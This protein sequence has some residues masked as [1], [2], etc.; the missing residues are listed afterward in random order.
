MPKFL[1]VL[2]LLM[3]TINLSAQKTAKEDIIYLKNKWVIR[4]QIT[5]S[6]DNAVTIVTRDGNVF[7]FQPSEIQSLGKENKKRYKGFG[8][9]TEIGALAATKNRPDNV[10]TAAF[11]FQTVNGYRF[12]SCLFLGVG[13]ALDLYAT[14]TIL[15][16]FASIRYNLTGKGNFQP[17]LFSDCGY[18]FD[19]TSST[20]NINYES[21]AMFAIGAG[22]KIPLANRAG[23]QVSAG[24]RLQRGAIIESGVKNEYSNNR[25]ALRAGFYL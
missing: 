15:P 25:I 4:G 21:G 8:H 22:L 3:S 6:S 18:G 17:F 11:T 10:T 7:V 2:T 20:T 14:Q 9:Y 16:G 19:I 5:A 23:F 12:N 13:I 1:L 24:Y